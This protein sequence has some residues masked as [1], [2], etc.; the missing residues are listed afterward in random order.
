MQP[1]DS[2]TISRPHL[3]GVSREVILH[4]LDFRDAP[5]HAEIQPLAKSPNISRAS[6]DYL[7]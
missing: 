5:T 1:P 2:P 3:P 6:G 7:T 4:L